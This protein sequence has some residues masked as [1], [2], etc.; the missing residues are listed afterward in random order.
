MGLVVFRGWWLTLSLFLGSD[1][2]FTIK[3]SNSDMTATYPTQKEISAGVMLSMWI[4]KER[5]NVKVTKASQG[6]EPMF[7]MEN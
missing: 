6:W 1:S 4:I 3:T 7:Q 2:S 5:S